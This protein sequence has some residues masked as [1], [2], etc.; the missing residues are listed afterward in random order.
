MLQALAV[1]AL[2]LPPPAAARPR[3]DFRSPA[4]GY[5]QAAID[6]RPIWVESELHEKDPALEKAA[7]ARLAENLRLIEESLPAAAAGAL[8]SLPVFLMYGPEAS[9]GGKNSGA[10][11][12]RR[13]APDRDPSLDPRWRDCIVVYSARNYMQQDDLWAK[14]LLAHELAHAWHLTHFPERQADLMAA[15]RG[16]MA[17]GLYDDVAYRDGSSRKGYAAQNHVEYFGELS[18]IYFVGGNYFP[19]DRARLKEYDPEGYAV[20]EKLWGVQPR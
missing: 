2:L 3:V 15:Y 18:A 20:V 13:S 17:K 8:K 7:L 1:A 16:A 5:A 4:R 9:G 6:G 19:F 10:A 14:K 11:Y 12:H